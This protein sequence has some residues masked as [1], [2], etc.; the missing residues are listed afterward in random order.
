MYIVK[1]LTVNCLQPC[2]PPGMLA[3]TFLWGSETWICSPVTPEWS[4]QNTLLYSV[5]QHCTALPA[6]KQE[7]MGNPLKTFSIN[8]LIVTIS[9]HNEETDHAGYTTY[10][11]DDSFKCLAKSKVL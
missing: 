6:P 2:L 10:D 1:Q 11:V 5:P 4:V 8:F 9:S 7:F 3:C